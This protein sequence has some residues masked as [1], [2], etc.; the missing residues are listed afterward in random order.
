MTRSS[1]TGQVKAISMIVAIEGLIPDRR[2]GAAEN[3]SAPPFLRAEIHPAAGLGRRQGET[4]DPSPSPSLAP[5]ENEPGLSDIETTTSSLGNTPPSHAMPP[6]PFFEPSE[7]ALAN[8]FRASE[9]T[10]SASRGPAFFSAPDTRTPFSIK[11]NPFA[12]RR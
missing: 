4:I 7:P 10:P 1:I 11:K 6:S 3:K 5:E 8:S 12:R 9:M 2:A